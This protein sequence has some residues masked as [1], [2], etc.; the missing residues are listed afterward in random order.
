MKR[1]RIAK[2]LSMILSVA[3]ILGSTSLTALAEQIKKSFSESQLS[4]VSDNDI[5]TGSNTGY[6]YGV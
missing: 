2:G 4:L 1:K 6:L 3:M 5:G